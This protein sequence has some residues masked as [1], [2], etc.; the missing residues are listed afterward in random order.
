MRKTGYPQSKNI[1]GPLAPHTK[2]NSKWIKDFSIKSEIVKLLNK[3][4]WRSLHNIDLGNKFMD[5]IAK[6]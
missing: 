5:M 3:I 4:I 2:I 1:I 6:I